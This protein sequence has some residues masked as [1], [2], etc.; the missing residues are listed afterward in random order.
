[1]LTDADVRGKKEGLKGLAGFSYEAENVLGR[2]LEEAGRER[3][4]GSWIT[5]PA[6]KR[7]EESLSIIPSDDKPRPR[8]GE[9]K[10]QGRPTQR[11]YLEITYE[12]FQGPEN[13]QVD[14]DIKTLSAIQTCTNVSNAR[15]RLL[16]F[17]IF[18][19]DL[20]A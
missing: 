17:N 3:W 15:P 6:R 5:T 7:L 20:S 13:P 1:V 2:K 11:F 12:A 19:G 8:H 9:S 16:A 10:A 18:V 4:E 14:R